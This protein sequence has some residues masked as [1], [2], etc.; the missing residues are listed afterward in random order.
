[1]KAQDERLAGTAEALHQLSYRDELVQELDE[2]SANVLMARAFEEGGAD[3]PRWKV[4][5]LVEGFQ[6]LVQGRCDLEG[7]HQR[8]QAKARAASSEVL[9][10]VLAGQSQEAPEHA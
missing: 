6:H 8:A 7:V 1:M 3:F 5:I 2:H 9:Q 4:E 10:L